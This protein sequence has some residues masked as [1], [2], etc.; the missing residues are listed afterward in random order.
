MSEAP[1]YPLPAA[2]LRPSWANRRSQAFAAI[3]IAVCLAAIAAGM[4]IRLD[5]VDDVVLRVLLPAGLAFVLAFSPIPGTSV[6]RIARELT[7]LCLAASMF[8]GDHVPLMLA[9][10]PLVLMASV[11]I[12]WV[13]DDR[14]RREGRR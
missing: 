4:P 1:N 13:R 5:E 7:V 8:A 10:Y 11:A 14:S 6:G 3:A 2:A 12:A 9:C